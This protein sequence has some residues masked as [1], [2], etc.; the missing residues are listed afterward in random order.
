MAD[1][2]FFVGLLIGI[3]GMTLT[4]GVVSPAISRVTTAEQQGTTLSMG[5]I[6]AYAGKLGAPILFGYLCVLALSPS[7]CCAAAA[8]WLLP[9]YD[10]THH[11]GRRITMAVT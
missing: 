11:A 1:A 3:V 7:R 6:A 4:D 2:L 9:T 10:N 8:V 5:S